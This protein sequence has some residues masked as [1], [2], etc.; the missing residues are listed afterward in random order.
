MFRPLPQGCVCGGVHAVMEKLA[1]ALGWTRGLQLVLSGEPQ[2]RPISHATAPLVGSTDLGKPS[3]RLRWASDF[4]WE[5]A[6]GNADSKADSKAGSVAMGRRGCIRGRAQAR[7][8]SIAYGVLLLVLV[9]VALACVLRWTARAHLSDMTRVLRTSDFI[10]S[11][12]GTWIMAVSPADAQALDLSPVDVQLLGTLYVGLC[13][14]N[15]TVMTEI[16]KG[17]HVLVLHDRGWFYERFAA[18]RDTY[19][20][21][22]SHRSARPQIGVPAG[23]SLKTLLAG[24]TDWHDSWFQLEGA[25]WSRLRPWDAFVHILN[26]FQYRIT[27]RNVGPLGS[28]EYTDRH[29]LYLPFTTANP[30]ARGDL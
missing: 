22:S 6:D 18:M 27:G 12:S 8:T 5:Q 24:T 28:S 21:G 30:R 29:P 26:Y 16:L 7:A 1:C 15:L 9:C 11:Q 3:T 25:Q 20:R 19:R 2:W 4:G 14:S 13:R 23:R 17:A 10:P